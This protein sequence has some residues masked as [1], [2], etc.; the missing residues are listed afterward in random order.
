M[1]L[2]ISPQRDEIK[3]SF[4]Q[5]EINQIA[6]GLINDTIQIE[7]VPTHIHPEL[8]TP[9]SLARI[10]AKHSN[11]IEKYDHLTDIMYALRL[12]LVKPDLPVTEATMT[13]DFNSIAP[14]STNSSTME[15]SMLTR[16]LQTQSFS[17]TSP[18]SLITAIQTTDFKNDQAT[19]R[20][21]NGKIDI[22]NQYYDNEERRMK[23]L[24]EKEYKAIVQSHNTMSLSKDI[25]IAKR[26]SDNYEIKLADFRDKWDNIF[27]ELKQ[28]RQ[29]EIDAINLE[30]ASCN[31]NLV[32]M[33]Q[34][35]PM[36]ARSRPP[37]EKLGR[38]LKSARS[39]KSNAKS[40]KKFSQ[41]LQPTTETHDE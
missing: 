35:R 41:T 7:T 39:P 8:F 36:T 16:S 17:S 11:F 37:Q 20:R 10:E 3:E 23:D 18:I 29:K 25:N 38:T 32:S 13:R 12:S 26:Q 24:K 22:I 4:T 28:N 9:I 30:M 14:K 2:S 34:T 21:T 5:E 40:Q 19:I 31:P 15:R 27:R 1:N 6:D 33:T